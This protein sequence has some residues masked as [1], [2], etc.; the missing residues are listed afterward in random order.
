MQK[1]LCTWRYFP[2]P[3][4]LN[5]LQNNTHIMKAR[6]ILTYHQ[7]DF[8]SFESRS[9]K[10]QQGKEISRNSNCPC[11]FFPPSPIKFYPTFKAGL[12]C[13]P[14]WEVFFETGPRLP[15]P[16]LWTLTT[17]WISLPDGSG[18]VWWLS[19]CLVLL[20]QLR[21][22]WEHGWVSCYVFPSRHWTQPSVHKRWSFTGSYNQLIVYSSVKNIQETYG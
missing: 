7:A 2:P 17:A 22:P 6:E 5:L 4:L 20:I 3:A 12:K 10:V 19:A 18:L 15:Y 11:S 21:A 13:R 9:C 14:M 8:F 1:N 16:L